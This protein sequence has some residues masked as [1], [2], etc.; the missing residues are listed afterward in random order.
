LVGP[1]ASRYHAAP[2]LI[3]SAA[4]T[5]SACRSLVCLTAV[6]FCLGACSSL[7]PFQEKEKEKT[8]QVVPPA[9]FK[10]HPGLLGQP[11]PP[12][13]QTPEDDARVARVDAGSA[14]A[15]P[16]QAAAAGAGK[17]RMDPEGL[18]TQRSVYFD[19]DRAEIKPDYLPALQA[20]GRYLAEHP[21]A[22]VRIEGNADER[23]SAYY[24]KVLGMRRAL[25]VKNALLEAGA[26]ESQLRTVTY[27]DT[28][29]KLK[30]KDETSWAENRR[31]DVVYER[32]E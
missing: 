8:Y 32:E 20:H 11:V 29:P 22:R 26:R 3:Q 12:E 19:F 13:L 15:A 21:K 14:E 16:G 25:A 2:K 10:V 1:P 18:R 4:M 17:M 5:P 9:S 23:G 24:N 30:G 31:A 7:W 6:A 27:G 28:R